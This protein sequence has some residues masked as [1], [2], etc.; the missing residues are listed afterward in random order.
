MEDIEG[1]IFMPNAS[2][3]GPI[4]DA[5]YEEVLAAFLDKNREHH[6]EPKS[7]AH[8]K[9]L[10]EWP[11]WKKATDEEYYSLDEND[12]YDVVDAPVGRIII[13]SKLVYKIKHKAD[14]SIDRY[15]ARLVA[16]GFAQQPGVDFEEVF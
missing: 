2:I 11:H 12:T 1:D 16:K 3:Y 5:D 7:L 9:R 4:N 15:K 14:G 13:P 10:P 6:I 8:A